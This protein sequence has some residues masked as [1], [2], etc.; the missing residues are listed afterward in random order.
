MRGLRAQLSL[1]H[2]MPRRSSPPGTRAR[3]QRRPA[4]PSR[5]ME[6]TLAFDFPLSDEHQLLAQELCSAR[7][8]CLVPPIRRGDEVGRAHDIGAR[9]R[10]EDVSLRA[11]GFVQSNH[12][13]C[14][15]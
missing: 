12:P 14:G 15:L 1:S 4:G 2:S 5:R 7:A 6:C 10:P 9:G 13:P 3:R 11:T 8:H